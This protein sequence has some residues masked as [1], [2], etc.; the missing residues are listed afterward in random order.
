VFKEITQ[1]VHFGRWD[2]PVF[3]SP[4]STNGPLLCLGQT[5]DASRPTLLWFKMNPDDSGAPPHSHDTWAMTIVLEGSMTVGDVVQKPGDVMICEP[6][7]FY[8]PFE[9]GPEGVVGFEFF[10]TMAG[11]QAL[12]GDAE[13]DP[14]V[15]A[16]GDYAG[17]VPTYP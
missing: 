8:G 17:A 9:P 13:N 11:V 2:E 14:R 4:M 12:W 16:L 3:T 6:N 1:G 15:L 10:S 7:V 5:G